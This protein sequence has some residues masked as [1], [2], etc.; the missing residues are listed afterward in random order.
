MQYPSYLAK[1]FQVFNLNIV[2]LIL[3][4]IVFHVY[5]LHSRKIFQ[6]SEMCSCFNVSK[7]KEFLEEELLSQSLSLIMDFFFLFHWICFLFLLPLPETYKTSYSKGISILNKDHFH[8]NGSTNCA[9]LTVLINKLPINLVT[10]EEKQ[11]PSNLQLNWRTTSFLWTKSGL[12]MTFFLLIF[13]IYFY[14][15]LLRSTGNHSRSL[16][17]WCDVALMTLKWHKCFWYCHR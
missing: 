2:G 8:Q 14:C 6:S 13:L 9:S 11:R 10:A 16:K 1:Y 3:L 5:P 12:I 7:V 4:W 17:H 15:G